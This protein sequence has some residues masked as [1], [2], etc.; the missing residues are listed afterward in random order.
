MS[1]CMSK[2]GPGDSEHASQTPRLGET[3]W[4]KV[5][6]LARCPIAPGP[7]GS[8]PKIDH[9]LADDKR[10]QRIIDGLPHHNA[11]Q[12]LDEVNHWLA[13]LNG[14]PAF[15]AEQRY[16]LTSRFDTATRMYQARLL[17]TYLALGDDNFAEEKR[18][19][20]TLTE[21]WTLLG[22]AYLTCVR[23]CAVGPIAPALRPQLRVL[24]AR[25]LRALRHEVKC[26][27][28]RYGA[29][30][31]D[32][33]S[34]CGTLLAFAEAGGDAMQPVTLYEG[35]ARHT[36]AAHEFM[37]LT[38]FWTLAPTGLSPFEQDIAERLVLHLT[39]KCRMSAFQEDAFDFFFDTAG[40]H[41]PLRLVR[42]SPWSPQ[43][44][45]VEVAQARQALQVMHALA[46][47]GRMPPGVQF[48]AGAE[49]I[50]VARVAA[51]V[52]LNWA[53]QMP[54]RAFERRKLGQPLTVVHGFQDVLGVIAPAWNDG[55]ND[56]S[57]AAAA[58]RAM[59]ESWIVDDVSQ[60]GYGVIV[61]AGAGEWLHV[62]NLVALRGAVD[63]SWHVGVVRRVSAHT[64]N[65][66]HIGIQ[67]L[68]RAPLAVQWR[69]LAGAAREGKRQWAIQLNAR[70]AGDSSV[71]ILVRRDLLSGREVLQ[72]L[73]P[74][75]A[76][77]VM[78]KPDGLVEAGQDFD[79]LRYIAPPPKH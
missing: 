35:D 37:R 27:L 60:G 44:R 7:F 73:Y 15:G 38:M 69:T 68:S 57:D 51:H 3:L 50:A 76:T 40:L 77:E 58:P 61:P 42:S 16:K 6:A 39:D 12:A 30:R 1:M 31:N 67:V 4:A 74:E 75:S 14:A 41:P 72:A 9:P 21:F 10:V 32:L 65:Q 17:E 36:S 28:L 56:R 29:V 22:H 63:E 18:V 24:A 43:T 23:Q 54:A 25:G 13:A 64:Q 53:R 5:R 34:D 59:R 71:D 66:R 26:T 49:P 70:P 20:K 47:S 45:Y 33:W 19:W 11:H 8:R 52:M 78:L 55:G 79:W 2:H 62:G 46:S 48:S